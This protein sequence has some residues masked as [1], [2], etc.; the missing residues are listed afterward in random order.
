[1]KNKNWILSA[2]LVIALSGFAVSRA[3]AA[4]DSRLIARLLKN[5]PVAELPAK[6]AQTVSL[7]K[8]T[9]REDVTIAVIQTVASKSPSALVSV[10]AS[11]AK[12]APDSAPVAA[13]TAAILAP[14][15]A[16]AIAMAAA[17]AAPNAVEKI[18]AAIAKLLPSSAS[19]VAELLAGFAPTHA[20]TIF[21]AVSVSVSESASAAQKRTTAKAAGSAGALATISTSSG[22]IDQSAGPR[23]NPTAATG[24]VAGG[25]PL[26]NYSN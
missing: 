22:P 4:S 5:V 15:Q 11:I 16:Q 13:A 19:A 10:V 25:D 20:T 3:S 7:A 6:A 1:M 24:E 21:A 2:V 12:A 23:T 9:D 14:K 17:K 26:R 8:V 18:A